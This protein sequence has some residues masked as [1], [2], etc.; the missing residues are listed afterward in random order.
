MSFSPPEGGSDKHENM[1]KAQSAPEAAPSAKMLQE[2]M[3]DAKQIQSDLKAGNTSGL[4]KDALALN[5]KNNPEY[6]R[7]VQADLAKMGF[8]NVDISTESGAGGKPF[9]D[10]L[11]STTNKD[12]STTL[13][14]Y[15]AGANTPGD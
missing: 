13:N 9:T 5:N 14:Q 15:W 11:Q 7:A 1:S 6:T 2:A 4:M 12:G 10:I 3:P 8:P